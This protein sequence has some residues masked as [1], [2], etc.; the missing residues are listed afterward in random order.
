LES[1]AIPRQWRF[2]TQMPQNAQSKLNKQYLKSLFQPMTLPVVLTQ[3]SQDTQISYALEFIPELECFKGHFPNFPIYPGVGQIGFI[4][5]FAK[6]NWADLLWCNGF[7]QLK[8][9]GLIQ[10][11]QT[12]ELVL[13]RKA[14]KV[15]FELKNHDKI[16]AS[17]RLLFAVPSDV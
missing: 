9:Q 1:I 6:Q 15:S 4:Q 8:F 7:E 12:V 11:Y 10:P 17:G 5:H 16:L 13:S 14:H 3:Q 2:L